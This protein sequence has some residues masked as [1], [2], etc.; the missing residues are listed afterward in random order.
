MTTTAKL[1][2]CDAEGN[3]FDHPEL[4]MMGQ[5][6]GVWTQ[7]DDDDLVAI[8][9]GT[10]VFF[11]PDSFAVGWNAKKSRFEIVREARAVTAML[12]AGYTRTLLPAADYPEEGTDGYGEH[13]YLP[14]WAYAAVGW[15]DGELVAA[16]FRTDPMSHSETCHYD[17]REIAPRV[18]KRC[19]G[20][21]NRLIHHLAHCALEYHCFAAKNFFMNRWEAP[22]PTAPGCNAACVGCI[23]LQEADCCPAGQER[24]E[25]IPT[26]DELCEVAVDHLKTV[27]RGIVSFGQGCEGE[28]LTV[29]DRIAE[30]V[31]AFRKATDRGTIHLNT[32]GSLP[33]MLTKII[34]AGLD[35]VRISINSALEPTYN[36]Y[37][38][39]RGYSF[40]AVVESMRRAVDAG[41]YVSLNYLIFPGVTDLPEEVEALEALVESTGL[42]MV[43][44]RNLSIDPRLYMDALTREN[45]ELASR[46]DAIG[47]RRAALRLKRRFPRLDI[48][49]FNRPKEDFDEPLTDLA[50]L[51]GRG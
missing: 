45:P 22:L 26:V 38:R 18:E 24:I 36:A 46:Q 44:F 25:F 13:Q 31:A 29:G 9:E 11:M 19:E 16:A 39:P 33:D 14:L 6:G 20:T 27:D 4:E 51:E 49:Y 15:R 23:S 10:K 41:L 34:D 43:H 17:D 40:A 8:P 35:S 1:L 3:I 48:G 21:D 32:N 42:H 28:P 30:A 2:L 7:V 37:F 50:F 12:Q 5:T 47:I